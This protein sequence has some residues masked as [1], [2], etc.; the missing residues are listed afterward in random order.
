MN[1]YLNLHENL[2]A[3]TKQVQLPSLQPETSSSKAYRYMDTKW[4]SGLQNELIW[5]ELG[6]GLYWFG[7]RH[8]KRAQM[9]ASTR[10]TKLKEQ[11]V[12]G[13]P[14][15]SARGVSYAV[16]NLG[17]KVSVQTN[18]CLSAGTLSRKPYTGLW[19]GP[20]AD[21]NG[22]DPAEVT[23]DQPASI[24]YICSPSPLTLP[25]LQ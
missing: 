20:T 5:E 22:C 9:L 14:A 19:A 25:Q 12:C 8:Q 3:E 13:S 18:G 10:Q 17:R 1:T 4:K 11:T 7:A 15:E 24:S 21:K 16:L 6:G 2:L 23:G